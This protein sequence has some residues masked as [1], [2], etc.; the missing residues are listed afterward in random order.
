MLVAVAIPVLPPLLKEADFGGKPCGSISEAIAGGSAG[1]MASA[2]ANLLAPRFHEYI[3]SAHFMAD[4]EPRS[5]N[6]LPGFFRSGG[7]SR[8]GL[9]GEASIESPTSR[10]DWQGSMSGVERGRTA[11]RSPGK[12][13]GRPMVLGDVGFPGLLMLT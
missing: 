12:V 7:L 6:W 5:L 8:W 3:P 9:Q 13:L 4:L 1:P 2:Q 10:T 11:S